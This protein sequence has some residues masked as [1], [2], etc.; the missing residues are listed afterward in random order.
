[1]AQRVDTGGVGVLTETFP[2][3]LAA[4]SF[5]LTCFS[6][7]ATAPCDMATWDFEC[8]IGLEEICVRGRI[9]LKAGD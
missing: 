7:D 5:I 1:M 4:W 9:E 2:W 6:I 3:V 8:A